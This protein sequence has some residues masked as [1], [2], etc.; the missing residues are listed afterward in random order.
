[1]ENVQESLRYEEC[2][3]DGRSVG[4]RVFCREEGYNDP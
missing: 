3:Q 2:K 1:V 4:S